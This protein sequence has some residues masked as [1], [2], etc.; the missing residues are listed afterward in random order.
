MTASH[1]WRS[2]GSGKRNFCGVAAICG[3]RARFSFIMYMPLWTSLKN[4]LHEKSSM[5][6]ARLCRT[7]LSRISC[8]W[9]RSSG[10]GTLSEQFIPNACFQRALVS[11]M[12]DRPSRSPNAGQ[13]QITRTRLL[14]RV[15]RG[16]ISCRMPRWSVIVKNPT[17]TYACV[18]RVTDAPTWHNLS[19]SCTNVGPITNK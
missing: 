14:P 15:H 9:R 11:V 1:S 19:Y 8:R 2:A 12:K 3:G 13:T 10:K 18:W 7:H 5:K 17:K 16:A 4:R 6:N